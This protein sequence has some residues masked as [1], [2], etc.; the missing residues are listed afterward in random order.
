MSSLSERSNG[1]V[2][3]LLAV[4]SASDV[5]GSAKPKLRPYGKGLVGMRP[6]AGYSFVFAYGS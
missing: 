3:S 4:R 6:M 2:K 5:V 1:L